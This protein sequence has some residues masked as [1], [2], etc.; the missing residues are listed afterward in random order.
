MDEITIGPEL[1]DL[2][3]AEKKNGVDEVRNISLFLTL[4]PV[5]PLAS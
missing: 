3:A 5:D 1:V 2:F 4:T